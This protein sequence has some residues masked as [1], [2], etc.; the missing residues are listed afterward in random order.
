M[1]GTLRLALCL[2]MCGIFW[3]LT[4]GTEL[5]LCFVLFFLSRQLEILS[6]LNDH[7]ISYSVLTFLD[8]CVPDAVGCLR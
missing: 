4:T 6:D 8:V 2:W 1:G 3:N 5:I 7:R